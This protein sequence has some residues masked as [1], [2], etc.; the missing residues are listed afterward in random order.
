MISLYPTTWSSRKPLKSMPRGHPACGMKHGPIALIEGGSPE[1][2][3]AKSMPKI[4]VIEYK[5]NLFQ[6]CP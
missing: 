3:A 2:I 5:D 1:T 6:R 4:T